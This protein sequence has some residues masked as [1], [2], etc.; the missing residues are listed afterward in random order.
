MMDVFEDGMQSVRMTYYPPCPEP[1]LVIGL[2]PHSDAA[3]ITILLQ[4][5]EVEGLEV[6]KDGAWIPV[7]FLPEA[8]VVNVGDILEVRPLVL[9]KF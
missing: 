6:K 4:V 8:F 2:T 9:L 1:D 5:N 7:N 3:G